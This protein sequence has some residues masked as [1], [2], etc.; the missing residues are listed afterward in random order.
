MR[1]EYAISITCLALI[2]VA[3]GPT[4]EMRARLER[5]KQETAEEEAYNKAHTERVKA[6]AE[7]A[8]KSK[9]KNDAV[10]AINL[11][12]VYYQNEVK[13]DSLYKGHLVVVKGRISKIAKDVLDTPY[14][15]LGG[16]LGISTLQCMFKRNDEEALGS[17]YPGQLVIVQGKVKG[18][19]MNV[20]LDD[21]RLLD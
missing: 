7:K 18:K 12:A 11:V 1:L 15:T 16:R 20:L 13:A 5:E 21:C 19:M 10:D 8:E 4:P 17:L 2:T 14:I 6:K 3:C 9:L